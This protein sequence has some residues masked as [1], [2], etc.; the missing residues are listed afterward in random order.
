MESHQ[1]LHA[2]LPKLRIKL[3]RNGMSEEMATFT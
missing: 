2:F 3:V 1:R